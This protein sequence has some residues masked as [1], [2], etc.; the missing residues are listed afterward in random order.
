MGNT[1]EEGYARL[2]G[3]DEIAGNRYNLSIPLYVRKKGTEPPA[4]NLQECLDSWQE[5]AAIM[6]SELETV[7][8]MIQREEECPDEQ[9]EAR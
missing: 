1:D 8:A 7:L 3:V 4:L 2:V 9:S 5:N 6:H